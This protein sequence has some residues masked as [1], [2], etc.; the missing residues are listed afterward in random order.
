MLGFKQRTG[1]F[2]LKF[3]RLKFNLRFF[4]H[5]VKGMK[6]IETDAVP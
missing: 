1:Y 2:S 3:S 5:L 6:R 4:L